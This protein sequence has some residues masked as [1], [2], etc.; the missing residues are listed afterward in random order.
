MLPLSAKEMSSL[1]EMVVNTQT[2]D[3]RREAGSLLITRLSHFTCGAV[4][5][6]LQRCFLL[7]RLSV[8]SIKPD[9]RGRL[10]K[11]FILLIYGG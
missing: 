8:F 9:H 10:E 6:R 2:R 5:K 1:L 3:G 11:A 4:G 7:I